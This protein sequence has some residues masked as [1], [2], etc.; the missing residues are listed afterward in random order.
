MKKRKSHAFGKDTYYLGYEASTDN[1]YWLEAPSWDCGWYWGLGYVETYTIPLAPSTSRDI[2]SHQHWRG[3]FNGV[4][5]GLDRFLNLDSPLT[6]SEKYQVLDHMNTLVTFRAAADIF[7]RGDSH[8]SGQTT[9]ICKS[10]ELA[11]A[12]NKQYIPAVWA[13]V[14]KILTPSENA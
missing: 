5:G 13:E 4:D 8:L 9:K 3:L 6:E 7:H 10:E 1:H 14:E 11:C 2:N 12:I